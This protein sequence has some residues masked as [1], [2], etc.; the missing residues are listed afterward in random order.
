MAGVTLQAADYRS[1][2]A[3]LWAQDARGTIAD[4][5]AKKATEALRAPAP[6]PDSG[7]LSGN[8][9]GVAPEQP[10]STPD[11]ATTY[12]NQAADNWAQQATA[13]LPKDTAPAVEP[14]PSPDLAAASPAAAPPPVATEPPAAPSPAPAPPAAS[15]LPAS[16]PTQQG[17]GIPDW[18]P[19]SGQTNCSTL[20]TRPA[21]L[22]PCTRPCSSRLPRI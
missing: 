19:G 4:D 10:Q 2:R 20:I 8:A 22:C 15:D 18:P 6:I 3:D 16:P 12:R 13:L 11:P 21:R 17:I 9:A 14:A 5:W 1:A 7:P